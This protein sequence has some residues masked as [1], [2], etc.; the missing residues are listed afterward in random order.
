M[1]TLHDSSKISQVINY[2]NCLAFIIFYSFFVAFSVY[3]LLNFL[4]ILI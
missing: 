3:H 2:H 1:S 4:V